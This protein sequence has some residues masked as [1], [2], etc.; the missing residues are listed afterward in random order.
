MKEQPEFGYLWLSS[1]F[2]SSQHGLECSLE[3]AV[4]KQLELS[5]KEALSWLWLEEMVSDKLLSRFCDTCG[6]VICGL[7][8]DSSESLGPEV[9]VDDLQ[10]WAQKSDD[11]LDCSDWSKGINMFRD[12]SFFFKNLSF[13]SALFLNLVSSLR[14]FSNSINWK[15][16]KKRL[17][18]QRHQIHPKKKKKIKMQQAYMFC[19]PC[20]PFVLHLHLQ[21]LKLVFQQAIFLSD[22]LLSSN[23]LLHQPFFHWKKKKKYPTSEWILNTKVHKMLINSPPF[24]IIHLAGSYHSLVL[25]AV[26]EAIPILTRTSLIL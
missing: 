4:S 19:I 11:E 26:T 7:D 22:T 16:I 1:G 14:L 25:W 20:C 10:E 8:S 15:P 2:E 5:W 18:I 6:V 23:L 12:S 9:L 3:F 13:F 21:S 17:W 24:P